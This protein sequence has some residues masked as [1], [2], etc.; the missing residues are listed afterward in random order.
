[1]LEAETENILFLEPLSAL[2]EG[3]R[4]V[5]PFWSFGIGRSQPGDELAW[6]FHLDGST[7]LPRGYLDSVRQRYR[8]FQGVKGNRPVF[9]ERDEEPI[10]LATFTPD[11]ESFPA[12]LARVPS[13]PEST[14]FGIVADLIAQ[15]RGLVVAPRVLANVE[16]ADFF[17]YARD[18]IVPA[19]V[20]CP[21]FA[22]LRVEIPRSDYEIARGWAERLAAL[23]SFVNNGRK[24]SLNSL[25]PS[26]NKAFRPLFKLLESGRDRT[27]DERFAEIGKLFDRGSVDK[28]RSL[29]LPLTHQLFPT[30]PI[31]RLLDQR[32]RE[33]DPGRFSAVSQ[34][35]ATFSAFRIETKAQ[36][37]TPARVSH[38]LP[39]EAWFANSL[40]DP[41]NRRLSHPFL[42]AHHNF[43]RIRSFYCDENLTLLSG[44]PFVGIPLP[45]LLAA[46]DGISTED[47]LLIAGKLHRAFAQFESADF[48]PAL[49]SP[50][51]VELHLENGVTSPGWDNLLNSPIT[52]WPPWEVVIRVERPAEAFLPGDS[53]TSWR[54]VRSHFNDK[55]FPA[56][57]AW[58]L[59]WKR[60]RWAARSG[61]LANEPLSWDE[62]IVDLFLAAGK[63][64]D[65]TKAAQRAKFLTLVEEGLAPD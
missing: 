28:E 19:L 10:F 30:G 27:L 2:V 12:Y 61:T 51:Q 11:G 4:P 25:P 58:M 15:L 40:V 22:L 57:V 63:H 56:L 47:L 6:V 54:W 29:D 9:R 36:G 45:S 20:F 50:W 48:D 31:A 60:F 38:L 59:D 32:A 64:L 53:T 42:K 34:S 43:T 3:E 33:S 39:P 5:P 18:G 21:S 26:E 41:L 17:V 16:L 49:V 23:H 52:I 62:R 13:L 37:E 24:G 1:M 44:D 7:T 14:I 65:S 46:R 35:Q 8:Q 55:F